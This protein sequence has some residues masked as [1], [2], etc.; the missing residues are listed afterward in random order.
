MKKTHTQAQWIYLAGFVALVGIGG[1]GAWLGWSALAEQQ[2]KVQSLEERKGNP[3]LASLLGRPDG[4]QAALRDAKLISSVSREMEKEKDLLCAPWIRATAVANG[5]GQDWAKD[6]GKWKDQ[7]IEKRKKIGQTAAAGGV[8]LATNFYL[9]LEAFQQKSPTPEEV[10][11]LAQQL[12]VSERLVLKLI[13][14]R[15]IREGYPTACRID[16]MQGPLLAQGDA[17]TTS[18]SATNKTTST[19]AEDSKKKYFLKI[20]SSPEVL[21]E[22]IR[23]LSVDDWPLVI[24][25]I[26]IENEKTQFPKRSEIAKK[27]QKDKSPDISGQAT[28]GEA[29]DAGQPLL[30]ILAGNERIRSE[31]EV[32]FR[33]WLEKAPDRSP[34]G[35]K[36]GPQ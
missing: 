6:P 27:F 22:Y 1:F 24:Q 25:D 36:L 35:G 18:G 17:K 15:G 5:E 7:L 21:A 30:E 10:P 11:A 9:G 2:V 13:E 3:K 33:P 23:L 28:V 20:E 29:K 16:S 31:V 12:S 19:V 14:A 8:V 34:P 32:E 4:V 26:K